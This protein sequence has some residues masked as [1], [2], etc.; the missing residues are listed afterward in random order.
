MRDSGKYIST[1]APHLEALAMT[2]LAQ[3]VVQMGLPSALVIFFVWYGQVRERRLDARMQDLEREYR[4]D[5]VTLVKSSTATIENHT[6]IMVDLVEAVKESNRQV[7]ILLTRMGERPC[8]VH[9]EKE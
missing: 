8:L 2:A 7:S 9:S 6:H 4:D 3:V 1:G 5:L